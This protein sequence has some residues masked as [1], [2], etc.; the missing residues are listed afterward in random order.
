[1]SRLESLADS[2]R[3]TTAD[4]G[5]T[6]AVVDGVTR[7]SWAE[8]DERADAVA[9]G[10]LRAGLAVGDRV[11]LLADASAQA[12]AALHG[13][14]R[15][16]GVAA[17]LGLGFTVPELTAAAEVIDPRLIV[18]G[19]AQRAAATALG[20]RTLAL[21]ELTGAG[22]RPELD[23]MPT[24]DRAGPAA[25]VLTSGTTGSPKAVIL[26][27]A[28]LIASAEAWLTA[29]P[30]ATGW[31]LALGLQH[32]AGLG[33]AWRAALSGVPL[34]VLPRSRPTGIV[35]ALE[36]DPWPSHVSLVPVT[37][38]R[39]LDEVADR[40]PPATVRAVLL[41]GGIIPPEL[42]SRA[43]GA[44][45]PVVPTYGLSEAGS[46][47]T[48]LPTGEAARHPESA[49]RPLPGVEVR[50]AAPDDAGAGEIIVASPARFTAY[51]GDSG[52]TA[53]VLTDAGWLRTGDFG[54]LDAEGRLIVFDRRNDLVVRGGENIS[55]AEVEAVLRGHPAIADAAVVGRRDAVFGQVPVAAIV[56]RPDVADPGDDDLIGYGRRRL[57]T[58]K[59]PVAFVRRASL[60]RTGGGKLR[61]DEVRA[62]LETAPL[63]APRH[64]RTER[65]GGV[66]IAYRS[67]GT[68]PVHL[69]V[70]PG[71]MSTAGQ[72]AGLARALADRGDLTVHSVDRRGSGDSSLAD[73]TPL[74]I[75]VHVDDLVAVLDAEGCRAAA[76]FGVSFGG[77]LALEFAARVPERSLAVVA[78]EPPYGPVADAATQ[79]AF[80]AVAA[81]T[82][83]AYAT[84]GA[85]A[86]AEAFLRGVGGDSA[87]SRLSER[88]RDFLAA[89]G[90]SAFVDA[91]LRGLDPPGLGRIDVPVTILT[92]EASD[93]LYRPI[94]D[95]LAG[96]I[97]GGRRVYL[98]GMTHAAPIT[99]PASIA[100]AVRA[101]LVQAGV[102]RQVSDH[103]PP[104][105]PQA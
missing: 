98:R 12:V 18:H 24:I 76:L 85:P 43:I 62:S 67:L 49:G 91:G 53:A 48:A 11:A 102:V 94:A 13:I 96:R 26:S 2:A 50:I 28:A 57:A 77:V 21:D 4:V 97:P 72:L 37:L 90:V 32:V 82:E 54:R 70:L 74:G 52:G 39:L 44:G 38:A 33:V 15:V 47:V 23:A 56:L 45:W 88:T 5:T 9:A 59:V 75:E 17:P 64:R 31:L 80:A 95:A 6:P 22:P 92:G 60:P 71:T 20:R 81:A 42:V 35:A 3:R 41:G 34:V 100:E 105:D 101:A 63:P 16:G 55:P 83:R 69:L 93:P 66:R 51:L 36:G 10:L 61:R 8:L 79:R 40:P 104:E 14:A 78:Y 84:G 99:E 7:W 1:M 46:G 19:P 29:L 103:H 27:T 30:P 68:G 65:A 86:A 58:F 87:W 25:I 73:P 89:E